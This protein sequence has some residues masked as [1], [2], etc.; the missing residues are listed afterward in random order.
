MLIVFVFVCMCLYVHLYPHIFTFIHT[1]LHLYLFLYVENCGFIL[2]YLILIKHCLLILVFS[3]PFFDREKLSFHYLSY[4][5]LPVCQYITSL[6][7][8]LLF[9]SPPCRYLI[10]FSQALTFCRLLPHLSSD[11]LPVSPFCVVLVSPCTVLRLVPGHPPTQ[12][13]PSSILNS[14]TT[15]ANPY[16][17]GFETLR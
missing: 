2:I 5:Y 3:L 6:P 14:Y 11:T 16:S 4:T 13:S 17:G 12:K 7:L 8:L 10:H 9:P 1:Y 15:L